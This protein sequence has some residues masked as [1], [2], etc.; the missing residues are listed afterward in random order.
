VI[1]GLAS[2]S[3][4]LYSDAV[5]SAVVAGEKADRNLPADRRLIVA[6]RKAD[7]LM[8]FSPAG[9]LTRDDLDLVSEHFNPQCLAGLL[10]GKVVNVG[11]TWTLSD[12][13][14]QAACLFDGVIK[15][16]LAGKL[17][18]VKDGLATFTIEGTVEGIEKGA[19]VTLTV[20]AIGTFDAGAGRVATLNWKQKD[21]REQGAVNPASQV[22]VAV[23]LKREALAE[24]PKELS[25]EGLAKLLAGELPV[26][27]TDLRY[28]DPKKRYQITHTRDWYVTGQTDTH[29]VLRLIDR[30]EFGAQATVTVWKKAE[31]GKHTPADEF[32]KVVA[33]APGW[34][35][36]KVL[37]ESE[38]PAGNGRWLYR[39]VQEGKIDNVPVV[40]TFYLL[41]GAQGDQLVVTVVMKPDKVKVVG[42][43]D[44]NLVNAIEFEKK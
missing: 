4:R 29:L 6:R 3:A 10:P 23:T 5:A 35:P 22:E 40:Q 39:V 26:K 25:D 2:S 31:A 42:T 7:G 43:R 18:A 34:A 33:D 20:S 28:T 38:L 15:N 24:L 14:V 8:C 12:N 21:D 37:S 1:D 32:K 36:G 19:K 27:F 44:Q 9:S 11:D 30:G 17:T 16:A 13:A 41:A